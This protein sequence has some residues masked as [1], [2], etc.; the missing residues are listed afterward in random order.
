MHIDTLEEVGECE[1]FLKE[2][3]IKVYPHPPKAEVPIEVPIDANI[4]SQSLV[5]E[6]CGA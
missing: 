6:F 5:H 1:R 3:N 2:S 4:F